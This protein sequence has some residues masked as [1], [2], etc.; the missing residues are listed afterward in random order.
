MPKQFTIVFDA[1]H[2]YHLPQFDP[3]IE[4]MNNDSRFKVIL[5]TA[6]DNKQEEIDLTQSILKSYG[7]ETVFAGTETERAKKIKHLSPDVF[8][9]GWSRYKLEEYVGE[10][11]LVAM[12]YHGIGI[13]PSYWRDNYHRL[14]M[15]FIEGPLRE[16]QLREQGVETDLQLTGFAKLD[17]LFNGI[18]PSRED[19]L[20]DL[21]LDQD[22][23][24]VLY[25]PTFYPS[26]FDKFGVSIAEQ[27]KKYNLIIKLHM[28]SYFLDEFAGVSLKSHR[29]LT[30]KIMNR[31]DHVRILPPEIYNI[32]PYYNASDV[33]VT[34]ASSTIYEMMALNKPV[35][36]ARF[37]KLRLSHRLF[38]YRLYRKR[39]DTEM[40]K[41]MTEFCEEIFS[42]KDLESTLSMV[43][44]NPKLDNDKISHYKH[45]MLYKLDGKA[46]ERILEGLLKRL[47]G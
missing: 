14:D 26:S 31:Y 32:V 20:K 30:K 13:K 10:K 41:E 37:Y 35:I 43:L 34:E 11:T 29:R 3:V 17:P 6:A 22:K 21:N 23:K 9:C 38:R 39:L 46:S 4:L 12:I 25:A 45:D 40:S 27:T 28:W 8:I 24:T 16:R 42:P 5:T 36:L 18:S 47:T 44:A 1:Y 33:L 19:V 2:L 7:C 15:R